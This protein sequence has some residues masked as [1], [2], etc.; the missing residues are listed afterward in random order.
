MYRLILKTQDWYWDRKKMCNIQHQISSNYF[1]ILP[2]SVKHPLTLTRC[3]R[4]VFLA[5][6]PG[7]RTE[8][9]G[10]PFTPLLLSPLSPIRLAPSLSPF[11]FLFWEFRHLELLTLTQLELPQAKR[12]RTTTH[13][14]TQAQVH[15][16][17]QVVYTIYSIHKKV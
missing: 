8:P 2:S 4:H 3:Q 13:I 5:F 9:L 10:S 12:R 11:F 14:H 6:P 17:A 7:F 1:F 15:N 16:G